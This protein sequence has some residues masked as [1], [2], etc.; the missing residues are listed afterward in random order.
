[1]A[2]KTTIKIGDVF[3]HLTVIKRLP[4][5]RTKPK[6]SRFLCECSCGNYKKID[7]GNL[8]KPGKRSCGC[9]RRKQA[10]EKGKN[11][12]TI[13]SFFNYFYGNYKRTASYR[14]IKFSLSLSQFQTLAMQPCFYCAAPPILKTNTPGIPVPIHGL[15]R[16]N[17][18]LG[19][20][21]E[22]CVP[23]C[24]TCNTMKLDLSLDEFKTYITKLF[25]RK[26][27]WTNPVTTIQK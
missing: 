23:C 11:Q 21:I 26:H 18:R 17:N 3:G 22:N 5:L 13:K 2:K 4:R 10:I 19:Y 7:A 8:R 27:L 14:S 12:R 1:V 9:V 16:V 6:R 24:K 20:T 25:Q 15:D